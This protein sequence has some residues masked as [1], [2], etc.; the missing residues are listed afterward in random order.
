MKKSSE[1]RLKVRNISNNKISYFI[2]DSNN[3]ID[4]EIKLT[5]LASY[6]YM[7][8]SIQTLGQLRPHQF[9]PLP[10]QTIQIQT[11]PDS[12]NPDTDPSRL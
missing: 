5:L 9:R 4:E 6:G 8:M 3:A 7:F 12:D 2:I 1:T 11:P 10:I